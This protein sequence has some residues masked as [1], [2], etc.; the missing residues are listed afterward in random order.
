MGAKS[1]E[2]C[3]LLWFDENIAPHRACRFILYLH[4]PLGNFIL[5][6]IKLVLDM[7]SFLGTREGSILCQEGG[8]LIVL[9]KDIMLDD[10]ALC[11]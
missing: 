7:F 1:A 6:Q 10:M 3:P 5:D 4:I 9:Q 8:R 2:D 11:F